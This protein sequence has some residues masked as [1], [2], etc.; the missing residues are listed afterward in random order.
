M[1]PEIQIELFPAQ[2]GDALLV[3]CVAGDDSTPTTNILI[4]GGLRETYEA[5]L[6]P[7][8]LQLAQSGE[9]LDLLVVSHTDADH[10]EGVLALLEENGSAA[11]PKVIR[12]ADCWHN[13]Y[14]HLGLSGRDPTPAELE[15]VA[16]Q[17]GDPGLVSANGPISAKQGTTL[18]GLLRRGGYSWNGAFAHA[19]VVFPGA[20]RIGR[21]VQVGVISPGQEQ[22]R[23]LAQL[24][25][26][27]LL[28]LGVTP[29]AVSEAGF[30]EAFEKQLLRYLA[31]DDESEAVSYN[32]SLEPPLPD[33]FPEDKSTTNASSIALVIEF[34]GRTALLLGDAVPSVVVP[35]LRETGAS[36]PF[37][38]DWVKVAHHGSRRNMSYDLCHAMRG[39][40][41]LVST[42]GARHGH[43]DPAALLAILA[44][45][46]KGVVIVFN[47]KTSVSESVASAEAVARY[48][49]RPHLVT[50]GRPLRLTDLVEG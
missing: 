28:A 23:R 2:H 50:D 5:R 34:R 38:V 29:N 19:A 27:E 3:R 36:M 1:D 45:Q 33:A 11:S 17:V 31:A 7:R 18:A 37:E 35:R 39:R 16:R 44:T 47:Y 13:S 40:A 25:R 8:L 4:D 12:I 46:P 6:R 42:D 20:A 24:W 43:P 15:R 48:G 41:F 49:H 26:R 9:Q 14:R 10:I 21:D 30:E 22:L 32:D